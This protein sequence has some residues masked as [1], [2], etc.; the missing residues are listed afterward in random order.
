MDARTTDSH[1]SH[2]FWTEAIQH[3]L[4]WTN[5][6]NTDEFINL[7]LNPERNTGYGGENAGKI[8]RS[9]YSENCFNSKSECLEERIFFKLISSIH[10]SIAIQLSEKFEILSQPPINDFGKKLTEGEIS[11]LEKEWIFG[12]NI[13]MY[14][15]RMG[16][17]PERKMTIYFSWTLIL[18]SIYKAR[19]LLLDP[20]IYQTGN[21]EESKRTFELV[22]QLVKVSEEAHLCSPTFDETNLFQSD[23]VFISFFSS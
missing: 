12:P 16:K 18:H 17:F 4:L 7:L 1:S 23:R 20:N 15:Q 21:S 3:E 22:K 8:W 10:S 11:E 13:D 5:S 9:I 6:D 2:D 19:D 14:F